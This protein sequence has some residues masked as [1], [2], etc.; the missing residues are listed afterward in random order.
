MSDTI[1]ITPEALTGGGT[2][3]PVTN[4]FVSETYLFGQPVE[5]HRNFT[6]GD[7]SAQANHNVSQTTVS[8]PEIPEVLPATTFVVNTQNPNHFANISRNSLTNPDGSISTSHA[9]QISTASGTSNFLSFSDG[10]MFHNVSHP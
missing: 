2:G 4:V 5:A 10:V 9:V 1:S 3:S 6:A 8:S 7:I